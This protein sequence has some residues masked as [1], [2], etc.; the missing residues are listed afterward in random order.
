MDKYR[1]LQEALKGVGQLGIQSTIISAEVKAITGE[2]CTVMVGDLELTDVRLKATINGETNKVL[3]LP[4]VGSMVLIGSLTGDMRDL[5]V[6]KNDEVDKLIYEQGAVKVT[7]DAPSN[8][9]VYD[10]NGTILKLEE[11]VQVEN[12]YY[13]L[14]NLINEFIDI[15]KNEI[16]MTN[17]GPTVSLNP[18][19]KIKFDSLKRK[20]A[21]LLK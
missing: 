7:I 5:C 2:S 19:N 11:K 8:S 14:L 18:A 16:H 20:F 12:P 1:Q 13:N 21:Q 15:C 4:K 3:M 17:A 9:V 6:L 10:V